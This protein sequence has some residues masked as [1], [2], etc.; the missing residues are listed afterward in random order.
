[1]ME[2]RDRA[3][4]RATYKTLRNLAAKMVRHDKLTS[5]LGALEE[6]KGD[7]QALWRLANQ[8]LG[9]GKSPLPLLAAAD[10][11]R[12][13]G[14][15]AAEL[16]SS[17][18]EGKVHKLRAG[19]MSRSAAAPTTTTT[20]PRWAATPA[21]PVKTPAFSFSF[22]NSGRVAKIIKK[23]SNTAAL[24]KDA[25]PVS[26]FKKGVEILA[27]PVAHLVNRSLATGKV[28]T[29]LKTGR[30]IPIYKGKGKDPE[31]P[32]SYRPVSI[33]PAISKV[34]ETVAKESLER[35][36]LSA[37]CILD[38]Q[39]GFRKGRSTTLAVATAVVG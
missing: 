37:C 22:T 12:V 1:M 33:L 39:F 29:S 3:T 9:K 36:L 5:N 2:A 31:S 10:G 27:S 35:H 34:L 11:T 7:Q 18:L 19:I 8:A 16:M 20:P 23:L 32:S 17:F 15:E 25:I 24:G 21:A 4:D 38:E 28:P 14:V 30:V 26:V 13:G 6:A